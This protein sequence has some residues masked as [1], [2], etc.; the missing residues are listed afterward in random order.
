MFWIPEKELFY[1][2]E[3]LFYREFN[4]SPLKN[5]KF[6]SQKFGFAEILTQN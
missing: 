1:R 3:K 5:L 4:L 6:D 2:T